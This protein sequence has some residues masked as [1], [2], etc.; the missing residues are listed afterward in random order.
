VKRA[1]HFYGRYVAAI[2]FFAI[3][4]AAVGVYLLTQERLQLPFGSH[5]TVY[6]EL[7]NSTGVV[8]GLGEPANVSGV[9]VGQITSVKLSNG[10]AVVGMSIDGHK[11]HHVYANASAVLYP[12]TPLMDMQVDITP[13]GPPAPVLPAGGMI[14][15][16]QTDVPLHSDDFLDSLDSDTRQYFTSLAAAAGAGLDGRG[17]D[18]RALLRTL[19]PTSQQVNELSRALAG[20][21]TQLEQL[22]HNLSI[23]AVAAGNR[24]HDLAAVVQAGDQ[25]LNALASQDAALRS[26]IT[27]L[28]GTLNA[29]QQALT[30]AAPFAQLLGPTLSALEPGV[31]AA[32][33]A[34]RQTGT[35][36][37]TAEPVL[38]TRVAPLVRTAKP[39]LANL[40]PL[41][42]DLKTVT[43]DLANAFQVLNYTVNELGYNQD[44]TRQSYLYW[45]AWFIHNL[46][47]T[48]SVGDANGRE[49]HGML[50]LS[51]STL[52]TPGL[53][54][55]LQPLLGSLPVC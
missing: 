46:D 18:L 22:V 2:V 21:R 17:P 6:A 27:R 39:V 49:A 12:N 47:S 4:S 3:A 42:E 13:G 5:Y 51:C 23:L 9:K 25:T 43:P 32:P 20:R 33:S 31:R 38:R 34:L 28:P 26:S 14:P 35:L 54:Q 10:R 40:L 37:R 15:V 36:L 16:A 45:A 44:P 52:T 50:T 30:D 1:L 41:T 8:P 53:S 29:A 19:G 11:L 24:D 48:L 55:L 7:P